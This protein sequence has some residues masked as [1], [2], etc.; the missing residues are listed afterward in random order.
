MR[1]FSP[2][3]LFLL[4]GT[5]SL[6]AQDTTTRKLSHYV[7]QLAAE[8]QASPNRRAATTHQPALMAFVEVAAADADDVLTAH[9]CQK[10][11]QLGNICIARIPL[12]QL[13]KLS[14]HPDIRRIEATP[15]GSA[16]MDTTV[17]VSDILPIYTASA[18]HQAFTGK[19]VVVGIMDIGF[20]LT[21]PNFY[22]ATGNQYRIQ[23]MWDMLST[24]TIGSNLPV[25]RDFI[26][27]EALLSYRY[28]TDSPTQTHGT[29]TLG[30][31]A[32]SGYNT[33]YR[34]VAFESD[35][36]L[37]S[38]AVGADTIYIDPADLYKYT[39]AVD[40]LGFK[41][42]FD[43]ADAQGKPCVVSF[44]EG[45]TPYMDEDDQLYNEFLE[46]LCGPGHIIVTSAGNAGWDYT[47]LEKPKGTDE[48]G[49]FVSTTKEAAIYRIRTDK[50]VSISTRVYHGGN[51]ADPISRSYSS[52][53]ERMD[54]MLTDTLK[55]GTQQI[56]IS[57]VRY[58][59]TFDT[60]T[61][62]AILLQADKP[63]S[64]LPPI[65]LTLSGVNCHAEIFGSSSYTLT[66]NAADKRWNAAQ[67]NHNVL[68][69]GC[70]PSVICVGC[71]THRTNHKTLDGK[72]HSSS[73]PSG[74]ISP[75]SSK[76][77][78][79]SGELKPDV[80]APG[81]NVHS[82]MNYYYADRQMV[83]DRRLVASSEF[84][85]RSYPWFSDSGTSLSTPVT[86]GTIAL[87]L[88]ANPRLTPH[89][90][91]EIL[92]R[93]CRHP[94]PSLSY[95]NNVYG[96][97]ELDG[98][99]GLLDALGLTDLKSVSLHQPAQLYVLPQQGG[100]LLRFGQTPSAP[101]QLRV[102]DLT[103]TLLQEQFLTPATTEVTIPLSPALHGVYAIQVNS[104]DPALTGSELVRL[105]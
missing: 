39:T 86:A 98:Y 92:A 38:N 27:Q 51:G 61:Y 78:S 43:Y 88:Q 44:S 82:S 94:E 70:F 9:H 65:A 29:L 85:G 57:I 73:Y 33:P 21:H 76:G 80:T 75:F 60:S 24:D 79:M 28:S 8:W 64:Q 41:Y 105:P 17:K 67:D 47:Y 14:H 66:S 46:Q 84:Q 74:I 100:L 58:T 1:R 50:P 71:T 40:A 49:A 6:C 35:I 45:Y 56:A 31:A 2:L 87:W 19:G 3:L 54:S 12:S 93:T 55:F 95:P 72:W 32:G 101:I 16:T 90:V 5:L 10:Y 25:G 102:Y 13:S 34:G 30:C 63:L 96:H 62:L 48:A 59:A 52:D 104:T 37:V 68:A 103:G 20:D 26:G 22:D 23:A 99:R 97:G 36:C 18:R 11:A 42:L 77:P 69:P 83:T 91:R 4:L 15:C 89:D 53:D 7:R 81:V